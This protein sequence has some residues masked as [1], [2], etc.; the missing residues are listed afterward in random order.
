MRKIIF[1][2][3]KIWIHNCKIYLQ[4]RIKKNK[5]I[6]LKNKFILWINNNKILRIKNQIKIYNFLY[7]FLKDFNIFKKK[8]YI[9]IINR[10]KNKYNNKH[11]YLIRK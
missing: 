8:N 1:F 5:I 11:I 9:K 10:L 4:M 2:R 6:L 3:Q 7:T